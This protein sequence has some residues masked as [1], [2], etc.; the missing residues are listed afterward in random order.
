MASIPVTKL[1]FM[2]RAFLKCSKKISS[3]NDNSEVA[4]LTDIVYEPSLKQF[5]NDSLGFEFRS[6]WSPQPVIRPN[7]LSDTEKRSLA[8]SLYGGKF[9]YPRHAEIVAILDPAYYSEVNNPTVDFFTPRFQNPN[10]YTEF[11][12]PGG[13]LGSELMPTLEQ[14]DYL[15]SNFNPL[16]VM[17][18]WLKT[19]LNLW[20]P[21]ALEGAVCWAAYLISTEMAQDK[22]DT[23]DMYAK[24]LDQLDQYKI[25]TNKPSRYGRDDNSIEGGLYN[26]Y[27]PQTQDVGIGGL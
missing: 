13:Q 8:N 17:A 23:N 9:I 3:I 1:R 14:G 10:L 15:S 24:Y 25:F 2:Q 20:S 21:K 26:R 11:Y 22:V 19:N 27:L 16:N 5:I 6:P 7:S 12:W 18:V 4:R